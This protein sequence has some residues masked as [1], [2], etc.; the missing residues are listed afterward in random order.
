MSVFSYLRETG[1]GHSSC[2]I[3]LFVMNIGIQGYKC[4]QLA[5]LLYG[6]IEHQSSDNKSAFNPVY[7]SE[8]DA[9]AD[10]MLNYTV[11]IRLVQEKSIFHK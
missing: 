8:N 7:A 5:L 11:I 3:T 1:R 10:H 2:E 9:T 6:T 4:K